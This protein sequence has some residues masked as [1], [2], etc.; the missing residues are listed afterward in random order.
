MAA[1]NRH[2]RKFLTPGLEAFASRYPKE[3]IHVDANV[4][5]SWLDSFGVVSLTSE[6]LLS[7]MTSLAVHEMR[8]QI[9]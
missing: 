2:Y 6:A 4:I 5:I 1:Q 7:A 9:I 8:S 3:C